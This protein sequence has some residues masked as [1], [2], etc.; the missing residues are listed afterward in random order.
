[1]K[2]S[3]NIFFK[4]F[5]V[6]FLVAVMS[7]IKVHA[8]NVSADIPN[9]IYYIG[10]KNGNRIEIKDSGTNNGDAA[11]LGKKTSGENQAFALTRLPDGTYEI[12]AYHSGLSLE[13]S[14]S[15][16]DNAGRV[17][18]WEFL[19]DYN[20]KRWYIYDCGNGWYKFVNKNS[21]KCLDIKNGNDCANV[22]VQQYEDNGTSAQRFSLTRLEYSPGNYGRYEVGD[23]VYVTGRYYASSN[24]TGKYGRWPQKYR[25]ALTSYNAKYPYAISPVGSNSIY[26]WINESSV[27]IPDYTEEIVYGVM[28]EYQFLKGIFDAN[29]T[30]ALGD[31]YNAFT[32]GGTFDVT[33]K[34]R[35]DDLFSVPFP[36][37]EKFIFMDMVV[38]ADQLGNILYGWIGTM[39]GIE[40]EVLYFGGGFAQQ[41]KNTGLNFTSVLAFDCLYDPALYYGDR[42]EDHFDVLR[43]ILIAGYQE[44]YILEV[45]LNDIRAEKEN[46]DSFLDSVKEFLSRLAI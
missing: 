8:A 35:W 23:E 6:I 38:T 43:G 39:L 11:Q 21:N 44:E 19:D 14:N 3:V 7:S 30:V 29:P 5:L 17:Q 15:S 32:Y 25:I 24:G 13:V 10:T 46:L 36:N 20:C 33:I 1:M 9:G 27:S 2:K 45:Q 31:F 4:V 34:N 26:G 12:R 18:Q 37:G 22:A 41:M 40:D 28:M 16:K 42:S